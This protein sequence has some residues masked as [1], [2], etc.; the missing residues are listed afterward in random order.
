MLNAVVGT[1]AAVVTLWAEGFAVESRVDS[2]AVVSAADFTEAGA[3]MAGVTGDRASIS[4]WADG[5]I[6]T[7]LTMDIIRAIHI[8]GPIRITAASILPLM[9]VRI[10]QPAVRIRR[11]LRTFNRTDIR[12]R[13]RVRDNPH[14]RH[15]NNRTRNN[16]LLRHNRPPAT[17][18]GKVFT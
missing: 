17:I 16:R 10:H 7:I 15:N 1:A 12:I 13:N 2:P 18:K 4:E 9:A 3:S 14:T 8:T 6:H 5:A 11:R